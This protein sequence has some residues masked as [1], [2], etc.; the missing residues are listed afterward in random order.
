MKGLTEFRRTSE[1]GA[2]EEGTSFLGSGSQGE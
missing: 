2:E 1:S